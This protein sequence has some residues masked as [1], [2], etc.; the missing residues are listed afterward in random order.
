MVKVRVILFCFVVKCLNGELY[1]ALDFVHEI[2]VDQHVIV[3]LVQA[4]LYADYLEDLRV[5]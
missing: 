5:L 4:V 2:Y 1:F 3:L